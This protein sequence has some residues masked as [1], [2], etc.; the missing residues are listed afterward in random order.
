MLQY[1]VE[2]LSL[3]SMGKK[4]CL[5]YSTQFR[6]IYF[7]ARTIMRKNR[8]NATFEYWCG[9]GRGWGRRFV[10]FMVGSW[11]RTCPTITLGELVVCLVAG[12]VAADDK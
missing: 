12:S 3:I 7:F 9:G 2:G 10:L 6:Y 4:I 1:S 5:L 11:A 8:L